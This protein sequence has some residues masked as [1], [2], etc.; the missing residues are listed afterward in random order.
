M[1]VY[2]S[3]PLICASQCRIADPSIKRW[4]LFVY[5]WICAWISV[6]CVGQRDS[7]KWDSKYLGTGLTL[8]L[9]G[10]WSL[11]CYFCVESWVNYLPTTHIWNSEVSI[12][13]YLI[14][15]HFRWEPSGWAAVDLRCMVE[16]GRDQQ[17]NLLAEPSSR[18]DRQSH[19]KHLVVWSF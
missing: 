11:S 17:M 12:F 4:S 16:P 5:F 6:T 10:S 2:S 3:C 1:V 8:F 15:R 13:S 9:L 7:T 14:T 19:D 18:V